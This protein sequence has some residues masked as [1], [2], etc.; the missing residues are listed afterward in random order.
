MYVFVAYVCL[1][2]VFVRVLPVGVQNRDEGVGPWHTPAP[3]DL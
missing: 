2:C 3:W 1:K